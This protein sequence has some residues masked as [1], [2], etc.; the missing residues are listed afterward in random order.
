MVLKR[1]NMHLEAFVL[2]EIIT[3]MALA[4]NLKQLCQN[5]ITFLEE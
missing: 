2:H 1:K 5:Y 4:L 3:D